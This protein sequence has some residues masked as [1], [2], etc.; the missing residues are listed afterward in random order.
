MRRIVLA[1]L[2]CVGLYT[3]TEAGGVL[4]ELLGCKQQERTQVRHKNAL[5]IGYRTGNKTER[6]KKCEDRQWSR[7]GSRTWKTA[8]PQG[9]SLKVSEHRIKSVSAVIKIP[10]R[11]SDWPSLG[12]VFTLWPEKGAIVC[13]WG[14]AVPR[15]K[16]RVG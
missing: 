9:T 7:S 3:H 8:S 10:G 16:I 2:S 4:L 12:H 6:K 14:G 13:I 15:S 1:L 11:V 5:F